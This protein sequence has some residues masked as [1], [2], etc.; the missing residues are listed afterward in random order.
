MNKVTKA[1]CRLRFWLIEKLAGET[2]V[3]INLPLLRGLYMD[4]DKMKD[5]W[6]SNVV[7]D[8]LEDDR[9]PDVVNFYFNGGVTVGSNVTLDNCE[10]S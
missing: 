7:V 10:Q 5:A 2:T 1:L 3:V 9:M 8:R 4:S 6:F